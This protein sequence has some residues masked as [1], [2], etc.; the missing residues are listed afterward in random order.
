MGG[1]QHAVGALGARAHEAFRVRVHPRSLRRGRLTM[2]PIAAN[3]ASKA[4]VNFASRS[5]IRWV[6][7]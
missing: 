3:T 4:S 7:R 5:R 2:M 6:N 1:D